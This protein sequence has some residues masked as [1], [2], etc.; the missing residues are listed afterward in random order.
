MTFV[1]EKF[2]G[3]AVETGTGKTDAHGIA[4]LSVPTVGRE[5]PGWVRASTAS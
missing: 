5:A 1:P 2:L 4:M 3:P